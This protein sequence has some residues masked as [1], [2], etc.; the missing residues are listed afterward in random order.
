ML[1]FTG[2]FLVFI[3]ITGLACLLA[4]SVRLRVAVLLLASYA[5]YG[6]WDWRFLFLILGS[7]LLDYFVAGRLPSATAGRCREPVVTL[8]K[9]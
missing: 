6:A 4:R 7:T 1:F 8:R 9:G 2:Q 3:A 5:F